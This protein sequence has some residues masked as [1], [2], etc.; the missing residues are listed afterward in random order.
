MRADPEP[1]FL[2]AADRVAAPWKN[3]R[4]WTREIAAFPPGAD[5]DSF[6]WRVSM[7]TVDAG[8]PFSSF[9]GVDRMLAVL[10]GRLAL[11]IDG[12]APIELGPDTAPLTF[13]GDVPVEA[14]VL[15]GPAT[16]LNMMT[17]RGKVRGSLERLR[18]DAPAELAVSPTTIILT[19]TGG[20]GVIHRGRRHALSPDD[21]VMFEQS[22]TVRIEPGQK[23]SLFI[24]RVTRP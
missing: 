8:G 23:S 14:D 9:P 19:R 16:D 22:T 4:G 10:D 6:D 1:Q 24:V 15:A 18:I 21:A 17:R 2:R 7:A 11:T 20:V 5:L 3:S 13:A 12:R